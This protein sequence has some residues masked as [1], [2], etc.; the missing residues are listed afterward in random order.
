MIH[1]IDKVNVLRLAR[2]QVGRALNVLPNLRAALRRA[3][4]VEDGSRWKR[5]LREDEI[6]HCLRAAVSHTDRVRHEAF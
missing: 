2:E 3:Q 6:L 1:R 5:T 4:R